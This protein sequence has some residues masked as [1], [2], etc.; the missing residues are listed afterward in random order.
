[1]SERPAAP[2]ATLRGK[3]TS[4]RVWA[5]AA[6]EVE[7]VLADRRVRLAPGE[8]GYHAGEVAGVPAGALYRFSL[9]GGEP[10]ADPASRRQPQGVHGPS[11]VVDPAFGWTDR[12]W[13][14][15][16]LRDL[17]LYELHVGTFTRAGTFDAVV[18]HLARLRDLGVTAVD[19]MPVAAFPGR[20]NWGYD[21]VFPFAVQESYGGPD[22]LRRLVDAAHAAG[23]AVHLDVVYNHL[24]PDGS[25]LGRYAPYFTDRYRTPWGEAVN[26]DGAGSDEVRAYFISS[27]LMLVRDLHLDGLRVDAVH[28]IADRSA[29]PFLAELVEAV[30]GAAPRALVIAESD[31]GDPRV[32]R[33]PEL[34]GLGF[35]AQWTNDLH[36]SLHVA[37]TGERDGYYGDFAGAADLATALGH[38][39]VYSGRYSRFR[40]RRH[41]APPDDRPPEQLVVATQDHDQVGN[42][43]RG[44]RLAAL[45]P[46][47]ALRVAAA[48][49]LLSPFTPLLFMGEEYA[50]TAPFLYFTDHSDPALARAVSEGRRAEFAAFAWEAPPP[51]PQDPETFRASVLDHEA[52]RGGAHAATSAFYREC[53]RLRKELY[54]SER[55]RGRADAFGP[56]VLSVGAGDGHCLV[57]ATGPEEAQVRLPSGRWRV[58]LDA[59]DPRWGGRGATLAAGRVDGEVP[60][61]L[62]GHS[63]LLLVRDD[64]PAPVAQTGP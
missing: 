17:V 54:R 26:F 22:G 49:V 29:R 23:L 35:D 64:G 42:R 15:P 39:F 13:R 11:A 37:L 63:A 62:R 51:D 45:V 50:E 3:S 44:E 47:A 31:L 41:G 32:I 59:D 9:D 5:P 28:A 30:H 4:F 6:R 27:A 19:L 25:V 8:R 58:A 2:G 55:R 21:G 1:M 52:A 36:H 14:P 53:L 43:A 34:G 12:S 33:P 24:G 7:V 61:A 48:A 60:L 20:R 57:L 38:G 56:V 18:P 16:P 40:R 46:P 10:L